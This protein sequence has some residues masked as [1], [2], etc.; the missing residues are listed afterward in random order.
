LGIGKMKNEDSRG[1]GDFT[2]G[3]IF[4]QVSIQLNYEENTST[5]EEYRKTGK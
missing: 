5:S 2:K 3:G 1:L 4:S